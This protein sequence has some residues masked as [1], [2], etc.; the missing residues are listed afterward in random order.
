MDCTYINNHNC[1]CRT[2]YDPKD[3]KTKT[4]MSGCFGQV[5]SYFVLVI[6]ISYIFE[7]YIINSTLIQSCHKTCTSRANIGY[8]SI[9]NLGRQLVWTEICFS[10]TTCWWLQQCTRGRKSTTGNC[11]INRAREV[12]YG[13]VSQIRVQ[14][15]LYRAIF[16]MCPM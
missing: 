15:G 3:K 6:S 13:T 10:N 16:Y 12:F 9:K 14:G 4:C 1:C 5:R 7:K 8:F 11:I 2:I